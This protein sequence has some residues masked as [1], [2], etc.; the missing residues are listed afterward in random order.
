MTTTDPFHW[1]F[2]WEPSLHLPVSLRVLQREIPNLD[3]LEQDL[4]PFKAG[5]AIWSD[6]RQRVKG[7]L[8]ATDL[9]EQAESFHVRDLA[10]SVHIFTINNTRVRELTVWRVAEQ[11]DLLQIRLIGHRGELHTQTGGDRLMPLLTS[12]KR[13]AGDDIVRELLELYETGHPP[14]SL[15]LSS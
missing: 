3:E 14:P 2:D 12:L 6:G 8:V 10:N 13:S 4:A 1:R 11:L 5:E 15:S 7:I 9:S